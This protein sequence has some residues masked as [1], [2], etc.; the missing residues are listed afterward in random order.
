MSKKTEQQVM[1]ILRNFYRKY[2]GV[3]L[4]SRTEVNR[5]LERKYPN[6][7]RNPDEAALIREQTLKRLPIDAYNEEMKDTF[8][9]VFDGWTISQISEFAKKYDNVLN[10]FTRMKKDINERNPIG[11]YVYHKREQKMRE[12]DAKLKAKLGDSLGFAGYRE[13]VTVHG[14]KRV[15]YTDLQMQWMKEQEMFDKK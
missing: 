6:W 5:E 14:G 10:E 2:E 8:D 15:P 9:K 1:E 12:A 7:Q 13:T 4:K 11:R 3:E